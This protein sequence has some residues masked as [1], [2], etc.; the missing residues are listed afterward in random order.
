MQQKY[1][2]R[3]KIYYIYIYLFLG[4]SKEINTDLEVI[5]INFILLFN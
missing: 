2:V 5:R 4:T 1:Q 3:Q